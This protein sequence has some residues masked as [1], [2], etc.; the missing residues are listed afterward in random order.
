MIEEKHEIGSHTY[1]H[2][3]LDEYSIDAYGKSILT[4]E[5]I[6]KDSILASDGFQS[7]SFPLGYISAEAKRI[8]E[9]W[10]QQYNK[11]RP[12]SS[13]GLDPLH[14]RQYFLLKLPVPEE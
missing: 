10:R 4:N 8:T 12:H 9:N 6:Y 5:Q 13:L 11:V 1:D 7:F 3:K 2:A 14:R